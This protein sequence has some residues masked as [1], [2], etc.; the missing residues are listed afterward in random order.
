MSRKRGAA[1]VRALPEAPKDADRS[2]YITLTPLDEISLR[3]LFAGPDRLFHLREDAARAMWERTDGWPGRI[4]AESILWVRLG[5]ARRD[6]ALL[7]V[8]RWGWI[9]CE[10]EPPRP[11]RCRR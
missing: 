5:I 2:A 1:V 9:R 3:S 4:E 11:I 7:V 10:V 6:G 8:R